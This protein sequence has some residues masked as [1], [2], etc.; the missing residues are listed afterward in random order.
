M[1][2]RKRSQYRRM[3][4]GCHKYVGSF[5]L[6]SICQSQNLSLKLGITVTRRYGKAHVRNRFKRLVRE[7][8]RLSYHLFPSVIDILVKPRSAAKMAKM[9]DIQKELQEFIVI[10]QKNSHSHV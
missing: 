10:Y 3:S 4:Q 7:A 2:L 1:R 5:I 9:V 6:V 8:F